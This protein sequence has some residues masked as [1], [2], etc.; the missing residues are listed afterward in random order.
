[1]SWLFSKALIEDYENS[2][3]SLAPAA[4]YSE[5]NSL[6]GEP[7]AQ[8]NVMPSPRPFWHND[9]PMDVLNRSP[10]GLTWKPLTEDRG[11]ELL[12]WYRAA[13]PVP[14]YPA[15]A[16]EQESTGRR[17]DSGG[18]LRESLA[19][20]DH[21]TR[22]WK[23]AQCSLFGGLEEFSGTWPRWGTMQNG[24][25][26]QRPTPSGLSA[27][28]EVIDRHLTI[29]ANGSGLSQEM[30][31]PT[32]SA[33]SFDSTR[34]NEKGGE[35]MKEFLRRTLTQRAPTPRSEDSQC[36]GGHRGT[37]D[38]LVAFTRTQ[39]AP[40][41][42]ANDWKGSAKDGQ[43]RGQLTDPA[44]GIIPA[45]GQLNP[46][47]EDWFMGFPIGWTDVRRSAMPRFRL[48]LDSHGVFLRD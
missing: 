40:T 20:F 16:R 28:R 31:C 43:R 45:G 44:M 48:W 17:A 41:P 15:P 35:K 8:L 7:C 6:D 24:V 19:K 34:P 13:F 27:F 3:S 18:S 12:T 4:A 11:A 10:F 39:H 36:A 23:T 47:W 37:A 14:T 29:C 22:S 32:A 5:A 25:C 33:T 26:Y 38:T 30:R 1:M 21:D 9:K 2:R 46:T 42:S